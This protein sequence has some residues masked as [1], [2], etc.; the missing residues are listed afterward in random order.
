MD[1]KKGKLV[2][3]A[4]L[5]AAPFIHGCAGAEVGSLKNPEAVGWAFADAMWH[6]VS[7]A[8]YGS[9][10]IDV[11]RAQANV[12]PGVM[13]NSARAGDMGASTRLHS[14][15]LCGALELTGLRDLRCTPLAPV[16][17]PPD[18]NHRT[19]C[20]QLRAAPALLEQRYLDA[21]RRALDQPCSV[22]P[23]PEEASARH[24]IKHLIVP[25]L[26]LGHRDA[27]ALLRCGTSRP[28]SATLSV[29]AEGILRISY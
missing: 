22:L 16:A 25:G 27:W 2:A 23:E 14:A 24:G 28:L 13:G 7:K 21:L 20:Y 18:C 10:W 5:A 1:R 9:N 29:G 11:Y 15:P 4:A 3:A 12:P 26:A 17:L 6:A 19:R 8:L